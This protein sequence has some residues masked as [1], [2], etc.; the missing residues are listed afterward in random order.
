MYYLIRNNQT[1]GPYS[2]D[3]LAQYVSNGQILKCDTAYE[4]SQPNNIKTVGYFLKKEHRKVKIPHKG[5]IFAQLK[6]IGREL[7]FPKNLTSKQ[8]WTTDKRLL[9]LAI[10]GLTPLLI[11]PIIQAVNVDF[12]TFYAISLYFATIWGVFFYY[13]FKTQQVTLK[14]TITI[15]FITQVFVFLFFGLGANYLN[16]FYFL[17]GSESSNILIRLLFFIF[18]VGITEEFSK[19]IPIYITIRTA[20]EPLVPQTLVYYGLMSGIAFGVFEGVEYQMTVNSSLEYGA[21]FFM[22]IARLT[23]LPF[24][25]AVWCAIGAYFLSFAQ[26]YPKYRISLYLLSITIPAL[27]H[28]IYDA[29][30]YFISLPT[31][32]LSILLLM[33][34]LKQGVNMQ[35]KLRN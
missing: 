32:I 2:I 13:L 22:N 8:H 3:V 1:F 16:V 23:S 35:S 33:I 7:I 29:M 9:V 28:G 34:Y 25:H 30:G 26:L 5:N 4:D 24:L 20:K 15:F 19:L 27:L 12:I 14:R 6:D 21:A 18:A 17:N 31:T 10:I 11:L